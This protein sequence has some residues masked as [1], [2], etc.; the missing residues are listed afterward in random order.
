MADRVDEFE[1]IF[2]RASKA[3]FEYRR[4]SIKRVVLVTDL[5]SPGGEALLEVV[6]KFLP[7]LDSDHPDWVTLNEGDYDRPV[8]LLEQVD[9]SDSDLIVTY[10]NLKQIDKATPHSLGVYLDT[11]TQATAMPVLVLPDGRLGD[12][13]ALKEAST[14]LVVT[15]HLA[16]DHRLI[17]CAVRLTKKNG[18]LHLCHIEDDAAFSYYMAA[19]ERIP[20]IN[21]EIAEDGLRQQLLKQPAD[22]ID[23]CIEVL[24]AQGITAHLTPHVLMGHRLRDYRRLLDECQC[25]LVVLNTKDEDQLAMHGL[26]YPIAVEFRDVPLLML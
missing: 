24:K 26:A 7:L 18:R 6:R 25:D 17:N 16:G 11:L 14:V 12:G 2:K 13:P 21:T 9:R 5:D 15:D 23:N 3:R 22:Y 1:S 19:V 8:E 20:T 4:P 10:R